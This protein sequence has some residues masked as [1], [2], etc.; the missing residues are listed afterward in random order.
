[1][2]ST[3]A[4]V[5]RLEPTDVSKALNSGIVNADVKRNYEKLLAKYEKVLKDNA[6]MRSTL[7]DYR[8][9]QVNKIT[10]SQEEAGLLERQAAVMAAVIT[11]C[12]TMVLWVIV[13]YIMLLGPQTGILADCMI[14]AASA[15]NWM[16]YSLMLGLFV[17][18]RG[19][20]YT[21]KNR[22]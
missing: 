10:V 8:S 6:T 13:D 19:S 1:M 11:F 16:V 22:R 7:D 5:A 20:K 2:N 21:V 3:M 15:R 14:S 12:A 18:Y 4:V 9:R 17:G